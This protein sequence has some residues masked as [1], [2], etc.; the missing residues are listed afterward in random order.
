MGMQLFG[1]DFHQQFE[2]CYGNMKPT[3][4]AL[5]LLHR[6]RLN[7]QYELQISLLNYNALLF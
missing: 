7:S 4:M 3:I 6:S 2:G 5:H 1:F